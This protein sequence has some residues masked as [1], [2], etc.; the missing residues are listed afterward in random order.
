MKRNI[1]AIILVFSL[2]MSFAACRKLEKSDGFV[3]ESKAYIVDDEGVTREIYNEGSDY[4]Y[5]DENGNKV[6]VN[7]KDVVVETN[8][9]A[10]TES[11]T[12]SPEAQ[13]FIDSLGNAESFEEML[14]ADVT[15]PQLNIEDIIPE[16]AFNEIDVELDSEGRPE[17]N[18]EKSDYDDIIESKTFT[19]DMNMKITTNGQTVVLPM[20][21]MRN[22]DDLYMET[23]IPMEEGRGSARANILL[24]NGTCYLIIPSMRAYMTISKDVIGETIPEEAFSGIESEIEGNYVSSGEVVYEGETYICDVYEKDG[25]VMKR[26]YQD[27]MLKREES[28]NGEDI[29]ILEYNEVSTSVDKS[30]FAAPKNYFD[31]TTTMNGNFNWSSVTG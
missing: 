29:S 25:A 16:D 15:Q 23:A 14:E 13:S 6:S 4:Y 18:G 9:V 1:I 21:I 24:L 27:G 5:I 20:K 17:H 10:V 31:L 22:G 26:Y 3:T 19:I 28:I 30:K 12:F 8:K 7:S 11:A 2:L